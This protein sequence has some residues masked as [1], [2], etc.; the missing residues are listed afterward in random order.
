LHIFDGDSRVDALV[1]RMSV[2]VT[3]I[4]YP[5]GKLIYLSQ[6]QSHLDT[7]GGYH[8]WVKV[9]A[10]R[11][12]EAH[13]DKHQREII[14]FLPIYL[15]ELHLISVGRNIVEK[16]RYENLLHV[17]VGLVLHFDD[18]NVKVER[19]QHKLFFLAD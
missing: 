18:S 11:P 10:E 15:K 2:P 14:E 3:S 16:P 6:V 17:E 5:A 4:R 12:L 19:H 1:P 9:E 7:G 13:F 8:F